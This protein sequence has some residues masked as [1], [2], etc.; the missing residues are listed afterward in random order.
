M[1]ED[2]AYA[3]VGMTIPFAFI[4]GI[5]FKVWRNCP[6]GFVMLGLFT[7]ILLLKALGVIP[8]ELWVATHLFI[9]SFI[10]FLIMGYIVF[11]NFKQNCKK[12]TE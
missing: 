1:I 10:A 5:Y 2:I 4:F 9:I 3:V 6:I 7:L 8:S 11:L 12:D